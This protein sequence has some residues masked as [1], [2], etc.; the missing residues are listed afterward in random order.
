MNDID[1]LQR[2]MFDKA[3]IRGEIAHLN[4]T[5][6]TIINQRPYPPMVRQLLGEA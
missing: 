4:E 5:F 1:S 2:F 6:T 3:P